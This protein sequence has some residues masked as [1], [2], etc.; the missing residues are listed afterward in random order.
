[1]L[2]QIL[3]RSLVQTTQ[4]GFA[5]SISPKVLQNTIYMPE[6]F[7]SKLTIPVNNEG[8]QFEF[9]VHPTVLK[10]DFEQKVKEQCPGVLQFRI[11]SEQD[12]LGKIKRES[13]KMQVNAKTY[14]VFPDLRSVLYKPDA[15]QHN[16]HLFKLN[17]ENTTM[18]IARQKVLTDFFDHFVTATQGKE[19]MS[20]EGIAECL[21]EAI[22]LYAADEKDNTVETEH[23]RQY[24]A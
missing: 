17:E 4:R 3:A 21:E 10:A 19:T 13:F 18:T 23:V 5:S 2:R 9:T 16:Q 15:H 12:T 6:M 14:Q 22:R 24:L 1:M 11:I 8:N 20:K 7:P